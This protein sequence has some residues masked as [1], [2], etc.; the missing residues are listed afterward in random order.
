MLK[1]WFDEVMNVLA[2]VCGLSA[3]NLK[4]LKTLG[5]TTQKPVFTL[6][7]LEIIS[8]LDPPPNLIKCTRNLFMKHDVECSTDIYNNENP[9]MGKHIIFILFTYTSYAY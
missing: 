8:I 3:V 1:E 6:C 7:E 5:A 2:I 9:V 4:V